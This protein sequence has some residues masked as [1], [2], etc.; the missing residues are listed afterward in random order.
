MSYLTAKDTKDAE[1][2]RWPMALARRGLPVDGRNAAIHKDLGPSRRTDLFVSFVSF[3]S[4]V[5]HYL[6]GAP[7]GATPQPLAFGGPGG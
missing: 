7:A 5:V 2:W 3:V 1:S 6:F 4:F